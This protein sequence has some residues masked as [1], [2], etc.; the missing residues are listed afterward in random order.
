MAMFLVLKDGVCVANSSDFL[1]ATIAA[2]SCQGEMYEAKRI[3]TLAE[4]KKDTKQSS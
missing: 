1:E 2:R 4:P 3:E